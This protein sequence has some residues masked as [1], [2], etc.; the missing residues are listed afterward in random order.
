MET[1]VILSGARTPVGKLLG[2][3]SSLTAPELGAHA[4]SAALE[5]GGVSADEVEEVVLGNVIQAGVGPN[6]ARQAAVGAGMGLS[7]PASTINKLC[8]SGLTAVSEIDRRIRLGERQICVAGGFESMTRAPH[9]LRGARTGFKYGDSPLEDT[10]N[11]D[12][13]FC[14]ID[15]EVMGAATERHQTPY[16]LTRE[17]LDEFSARSHQRAA[18]ATNNTTLAEEIAPIEISKRGKTVTVDRDEG[19]RG[20]TTAESLANLRPA[21]AADGLLTAGSS[22]QLSDGGCGFVLMSRS[23]AERRGLPWIAEIL[24]TSAVAGPDTSLLFQPANAIAQACARAN[25]TAADLDLVEIN[26]AFASVALLS[27]RELGLPLERVNPDGGAIALGHP[28]GMSGARILLTL[29]YEL[30]RR[31]GGTGAA[32]LCGGGGQGDA[33]VVRVP[34]TRAA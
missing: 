1:T 29:V 11:R 20:D 9:V 4:I 2:A 12:G 26:E 22:S 10:L 32:A 15:H 23:E 25:L 27:A 31:G 14:A 28:L 5:R 6:P 7:T 19:I 24:A 16:A 30:G 18:E 3:L 34:A 21:F 13:L 8:P 17:E 33:A